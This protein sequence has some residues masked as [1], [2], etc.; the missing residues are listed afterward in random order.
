MT[1]A[2]AA[3]TAGWHRSTVRL[4]T[5]PIAQLPDYSHAE[6]VTGSVILLGIGIIVLVASAIIWWRSR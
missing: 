6:V 1:A 2:A 5:E 4:Y 3:A